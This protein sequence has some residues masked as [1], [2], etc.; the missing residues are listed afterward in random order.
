MTPLPPGR[1]SRRNFAKSGAEISLGTLGGLTISGGCRYGTPKQT[2]KRY[3]I[4]GPSMNP[5]LWGPSRSLACE[6]CGI[7]IRVDSSTLQLAMEGLSQGVLP[8]SALACWHCGHVITKTQVRHGLATDELPP[9]VVEITARARRDFQ[10]GAMVLIERQGTHAK[11]LLGVPGQTISRDRLGRLQIDGQLPGFSSLPQIT[12]DAD[13]CR[14]RSRWLNE[15]AST[16]WQRQTDRSWTTHSDSSWL[17]YHHQNV[18]RGKHS[19]RVLDD[20]PGNLGVQRS[21]FPAA[22]L[23]IQFSLA[24]PVGGEQAAEVWTAIWTESGVVLQQQRVR[25]RANIAIPVQTKNP[26][27]AGSSSRL[28][29]P[30]DLVTPQTPVALRIAAGPR[31]RIDLSDLSVNRTVVYRDTAVVPRAKSANPARPLQYPQRLGDDEWFV[32]GDNVPLSIDSRHWGV[33]TTAEILGC[34]ELST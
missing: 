24:A 17:V 27:V 25:L 2:P 16:G 29:L 11:R 31:S 9:D 20:Y 5:T 23:S 4:S 18:Y 7:R 8:A 14:E 3:R 21:L 33:V 13:R 34:I 10:P 26:A 1:V 28:H 22:G 32:V 19:G 30:T 6:S 15:A 12:V